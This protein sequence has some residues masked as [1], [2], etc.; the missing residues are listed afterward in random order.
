MQLDMEQDSE[1]NVYLNQSKKPFQNGDNNTIFVGHV[2][3]F[4][5]IMPTWKWRFPVRKYRMLYLIKENNNSNGSNIYV[6]NRHCKT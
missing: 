2:T 4:S 5:R 3:S 1:T 6:D